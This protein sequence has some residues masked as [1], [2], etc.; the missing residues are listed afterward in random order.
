MANPSRSNKISSSSIAWIL[1]LDRTPL[2]KSLFRARRY[3]KVSRSWRVS[4]TPGVATQCPASSCRTW[5]CYLCVCTVHKWQY[6]DNWQLCN[7]VAEWQKT[8]LL[9][10]YWLHLTC[11]ILAGFTFSLVHESR[12]IYL[13]FI[14]GRLVSCLPVTGWVLFRSRSH[15]SWIVSEPK[16]M[17]FLWNDFVP[18]D[19]E[20]YRAASMFLN[21]NV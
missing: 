6:I 11:M 18:W 5:S 8:L 9:V 12:M 2:S 3:F 15:M 4:G 16:V 1:P 17:P 10:M 20:L 14:P 13:A 7:V 19:Q 21:W